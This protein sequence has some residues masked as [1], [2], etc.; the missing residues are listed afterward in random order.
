MRLAERVFAAGRLPPPGGMLQAATPAGHELLSPLADRRLR[1][2]MTASGLSLRALALKDRQH[3]LQLHVDGVLRRPGHS[4][5]SSR[6]GIR[7]GLR[8]GAH[9]AGCAR[10]TGFA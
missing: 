5:F 6:S 7:A 8:A 4:W 3:D 10:P 2:A 1:D 9:P